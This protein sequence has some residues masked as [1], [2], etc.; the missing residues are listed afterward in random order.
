MG[1]NKRFM[2]A[3][4]PLI[5]EADTTDEPVGDALPSLGKGDRI[6]D[7]ESEEVYMQVMATLIDEIYANAY[8]NFEIALCEIGMDLD[9]Q[10]TFQ[11]YVYCFLMNKGFFNLP[12]AK[13]SRGLAIAISQAAECFHRDTGLFGDFVLSLDA[14]YQELLSEQEL[15]S[16]RPMKNSGQLVG[17]IERIL[18]RLG[19]F[20]QP[21]R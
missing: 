5:D 13:S 18:D 2:S 1:F 7:N 8:R 3:A 6:I 10:S 19:P 15:H 12:G 9:C 11:A 16:Y 14:W 17:L 4:V 21:V 20:D